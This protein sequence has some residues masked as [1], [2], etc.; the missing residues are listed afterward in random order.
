M[1]MNTITLSSPVGQRIE[2]ADAALHSLLGSA[3]DL[4]DLLRLEQSGEVS[5]AHLGHGQVVTL[6]GLGRLL[7]CAIDSVQ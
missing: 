5:V 3:Q 2:A 4:L 1:N 6:L 7:P